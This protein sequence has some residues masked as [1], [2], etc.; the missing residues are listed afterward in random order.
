MA[1][2]RAARRRRCR[3]RRPS[4][5]DGSALGGRRR[6]CEH[7]EGRTQ[8]RPSSVNACRRRILASRYD[9]SLTRIAGALMTE[10]DLAPG[11]HPI[12]PAVEAALAD[13]R[14]ARIESLLEIARI[15][16]VSALHEH[17]PD[18]VAT[19]EWIADRLRRLGRDRGRGH[20]DRPP[21]DRLRPDPRGAGRADGHRLLPLRRPA[22]RPARPVGA[23]PVRALRPRWPVHRP[24]RLRRQGAARHAPRPRSRR[25]ARSG[26]R[27]RSTSRSCS[28]ARRSTGR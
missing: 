18:M 25:C 23:S 3:T 10:P 20:R 26:G 8:V 28:R 19:A 5:P 14:E 1:A 13:S 12:D 27:P 17:A 16:S 15:P 9:R 22:R 21:S 6:P 7:P 4:R 11:A 2:P 24:R